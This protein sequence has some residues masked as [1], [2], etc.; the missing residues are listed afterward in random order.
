MLVSDLA[1]RKADITFFSFR[2]S[3]TAS[4]IDQNFPS[5]TLL[6][7]FL[8]RLPQSFV[9]NDSAPAQDFSSD[10]L[11]ILVASPSTSGLSINFNLE[12][13]TDDVLTKMDATQ[14]RHFIID[15]RHSIISPSAWVTIPKIKRSFYF[16]SSPS[17]H[18]PK[19]NHILSSFVSGGLS[20]YRGPADFLDN[21]SSFDFFSEVIQPY[22]A[23]LD[24][25]LAHA[26]SK[27]L[28]I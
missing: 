19:M 11:T 14:L 23:L 18:I 5:T 21:Q 28:N 6:L 24:V 16:T 15:A 3:V 25:Q 13:A 2:S 9:S 20:I 4:D 1:N 10:I 12:N 27:I 17:S 8:L 26:L 22:T 7:E